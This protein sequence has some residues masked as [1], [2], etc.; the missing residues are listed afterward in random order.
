MPDITQTTLGDRLRELGNIGCNQALNALSQLTSTDFYVHVPDIELLEYREMPRRLGD[1]EAETVSVMLSIS[2]ELRGLFL[3]LLKPDIA[4]KILVAMGVEPPREFHALELRQ[5]SALT[6]L[7][8]IMCS[9]YMNA[10]SFMTG[11]TIDFSVP[12]CAVDMLGAI[13]SLPIIRFAQLDS[14]MLYI[15]NVFTIEGKDWVG[16]TLFLPEMDSAATLSERLGAWI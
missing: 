8:N 7:G 6:E 16:S 9:S 5:L 12:S 1:E 10:V 3:L 11:L 4:S 14:K 15:E 2:G 13:L